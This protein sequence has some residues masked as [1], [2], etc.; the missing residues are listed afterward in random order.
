M[1]KSLV[2]K[3]YALLRELEME[4]AET[5]NIITGETGAGKSIMLG[6]IGLLMGR[7]ADTRV[8]YDEDKKCVIE[9]TFTV[10]K[11]SL[12]PIFEEVS[13]D[14]DPE[15]II[16]REIN[17]GGKSRAFIN[18]TPVRLETLREFGRFLIEIHSQHDSLMLG[19]STYQLTLIDNYAQSDE[20]IKAYRQSLLQYKRANTA[21][22]KLR[23]RADDLRKEGDYNQFMLKELQDAQLEAGEQEQ[24][25]EDLQMME[26][27]ASIKEQLATTIHLLNE[28]EASVDAVLA[29]ISQALNKIAGISSKYD[30]LLQRVDSSLIELRDVSTE[31]EGLI[32]DIDYDP[33][34]ISQMQERLDTFYK[35]QK[36]HQ[37]NS[38]EELIKI[39]DDLDE[40]V[41]RVL[42][43]DEEL[44][45]LQQKRADSRRIMMKDAEALSELRMKYFNEF[46]SLII[47]LLQN[48][49]IPDARL[50]I[51][52]KIVEPGELGVDDIELLFTANKGMA[53]QPL[54]TVASG[55]EFSRLMFCIK[56]ILADRMS[57]PTIIFDEIDTGVSGEIALKMVNMMKEMASRHQV[58]TISHLPQV[59]AKGDYHYFVFKDN[60]AEKAV[61]RIRK[62]NEGERVEEIAK[63]IGGDQPSAIAYENAKEL[64]ER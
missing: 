34:K 31:A 14:Y 30:N 21:Y 13:L 42:N 6:A 9:G 35:L 12:E 49:G 64:L 41:N 38:V 23:Q 3:N 51:D 50:E 37:V 61:S 11:F 44:E 26:N 54:K 8:L 27:A 17:P 63:M 28:S 57:L 2:I 52:H 16:R 29:Q 62:L 56:Y 43:L 40:K 19:D 10:S 45:Q 24:L 22:Q 60:T 47:E 33:E 59:A 15:C 25:E 20:L 5:L 39:Q 4:P 32:M 7:R 55:G 48:L 46:S 58:I 18:D 36:K 1:L 53:P